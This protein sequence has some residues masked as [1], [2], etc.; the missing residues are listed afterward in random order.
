MPSLR[1]LAIQIVFVLSL[2]HALPAQ[3]P[4]RYLQPGDSV[5]GQL[6][7]D[8]DVD[9]FGFEAFAGTTFDARLKT[10]GFSGR[11]E[12]FDLTTEQRLDPGSVDRLKKVAL[13]STGAYA[14]RVVGESGGFGAYALKT[15]AKEPR[16]V[17]GATVELSVGAAGTIE[18]EFAGRPGALLSGVIQPGRDSFATP[19]AMIAIERP[20]G[21]AALL[22][23]TSVRG[24]RV[25]FQ[26]MELEVFGTHRL[27]VT[28]HGDAGTL[29]IQLKIKAPRSKS[30]K[31]DAALALVVDP[32]ATPTNASTVR[33]T[34]TTSRANATIL[35]TGGASRV[36]GRS[37]G[38]CAFDVDVPLATNRLNRLH[39]I[40]TTAFGYCGPAYTVVV[41]HDLEAPF[42][43]I[44]HPR[45]GARTARSSVTVAGR[46]SDRL[47]GLQDLGIFVN[48]VRATIMHGPDGV[49]TFEAR[50]VPLPLGATTI[51]DASAR[52]RFTNTGIDVRP[53][54]HVQPSGSYLEIVSGDQQSAVV[55]ALL[56]QPIVVLARSADG[57]ARANQ[58]VT[59][60]VA[61]GDGFVRATL[62]S[63][64][65]RVV[66]LTTDAA[67]MASFYWTLGSTAGLS[68][69]RVHVLAGGFELDET[70]LA[71]AMPGV[72]MRLVVHGPGELVAE[73]GAPASERA[74]VCLVDGRN[75]IAG[76]P[77]AF[78]V[79]AGDATLG[80]AS[81][82]S[83]E[84]FTDADGIA[85]VS[86][87][88]GSAAG[89]SRIMATYSGN[90]SGPVEVRLRTLE[91]GQG[92]THVAGLVRDAAGRVLEHATCALTTKG[93]ATVTTLSDAE[94]RFTFANLDAY[95]PA[96]LF[97][98]GASVVAASGTPV[99][100]QS[101]GTERR[102]ELVLGNRTTEL[103][104]VRLTRLDPQHRVANYDGSTKLTLTIG[105]VA[106][107]S[108]EI[109]AG[110]MR[111]GAGDLVSPGN[112]IDVGLDLANVDDLGDAWPSGYAP[113]LAW[114][115]T[116][117]GA[118]FD[119]SAALSIANV[120]GAP[121]GA[122][123]AVLGYDA[124]NQRF[125]VVGTAT[126]TQDGRS[127]A[128]D[129]LSGVRFGGPGAV[130]LQFSE[131]ATVTHDGAQGIEDVFQAD[132]GLRTADP[133]SGLARHELC[134]VQAARSVA[135]QDAFQL[136]VMRA[137]GDR[138]A[139]RG[140]S[141]DG[142]A[143]TLGSWTPQNDLS[144][145]DLVSVLAGLGHHVPFDVL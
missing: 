10:D 73:T 135:G 117:R 3:I 17:K 38:R 60:E 62:G 102:A 23:V 95:G 111:D 103:T 21:G 98:D 79:T 55:G 137:Y 109:A 96:E 131:V 13:P 1:L 125:E 2:T 142:V 88:G 40:E 18:V 33:L 58:L 26:D 93:G 34:G 134:V 70:V 11:I 128:S 82:R 141:V 145:N 24:T 9:V 20:D 83:L 120:V 94:G 44:D 71:S 100:L 27:V 124:R 67:G 115:L 136:A 99:A 5:F 63:T 97:V 84:V 25:Q 122:R 12:L 123:L 69:Q 81:A 50:D 129:D 57:S 112:T 85:A 37:D 36:E 86:V 127:I 133:T 54:E 105:S 65:E 42:L 126:V 104:E 118:S 35:V 75:G 90:T 139:R 132:L 31:A 30:K 47:S 46:V 19:S 106:D 91:R 92:G 76:V 114:D 8:Q 16:E 29:R 61:A 56:P 66:Q 121:A 51:L 48:G 68:N 32:V 45:S 130:A 22:P 7:D 87:H 59:V 53:F 110:S 43:R 113:I 14:L 4:E 72:P 41:V 78:T 89:T 64:D 15:K 39:V 138:I 116:P 107:L 74:R 108:I 140:R 28:N 101:Y 119:V 6:A 77:I 49:G 52:D 143:S 144:E 80:E